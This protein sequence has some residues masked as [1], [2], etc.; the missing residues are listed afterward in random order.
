MQGAWGRE[1]WGR[2]SVTQHDGGTTP[3]HAANQRPTLVLTLVLYHTMRPHT[4]LYMYPSMDAEKDTALNCGHTLCFDCASKLD[5]C[6]SCR[7]DIT[8]RV[9]LF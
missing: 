7:E 4:T 6:P 2:D 3:T 5:E 9:K 1:K 8:L